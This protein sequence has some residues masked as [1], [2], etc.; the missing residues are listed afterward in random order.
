MYPTETR[1]KELQERFGVHNGRFFGYYRF[2]N[3]NWYFTTMEITSKTLIENIDKPEW[4]CYGD[5]TEEDAARLQKLLNPG[6]A[7][8]MGWKELPPDEKFDPF[9]KD[10]NGIWMI[11]TS[12]GVKF[13]FRRD[14]ANNG[15]FDG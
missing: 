5:V 2:K 10:G 8:I 15:V 9:F 12:E 7:L 14:R 13:D 6:E 4:F 3:L 1:I 11:I